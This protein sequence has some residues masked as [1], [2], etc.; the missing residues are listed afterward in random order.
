MK[1]LIATQN[2]H[3]KQELMQIFEGND[4]DLMDLSFYQDKDEVDED[5]E[6]FLDNAIIKARYFSHKYKMPTMA[7]DSGLVVNALNGRPGIYSKRYSGGDDRGN[8]L[9]LLDEMKD[10]SDRTAYFV[11]VIVVYFPDDIYVHFEGRV[12]GEIAREP[13]GVNGFGYDPIFYVPSHDKHMAQLQPKIKNKISHR[14]NAMKQ[15]KEHLNEII[16]HK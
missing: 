14:A 10:K 7:D 8:Y 12:Y 15:V 5:G 3:K 9:K 1:L 16:N 2:Q 11:S 4:I 6:T 13:K